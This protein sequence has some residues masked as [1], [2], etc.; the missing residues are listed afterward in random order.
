MKTLFAF[1]VAIWPTLAATPAAAETCDPNYEGTCVP[2][3]FDVDCAGGRGNGP[4]YVMG[5]VFVVGRDIYKLD[6]DGDGKACEPR[7]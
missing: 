2:V 3:A 7:R 1:A 6:Q 5:P 4:A